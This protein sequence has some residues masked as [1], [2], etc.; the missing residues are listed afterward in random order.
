VCKDDRVDGNPG[1]QGNCEAEPTVPFVVDTALCDAY[2]GTCKDDG[3]PWRCASEAA[4][5]ATLDCTV[6]FTRTLG[7]ATLPPAAAL[8]PASTAPVPTLTA[9]APGCAYSLLGGTTQEGYDVG[10]RAMGSGDPP[11]AIHLGCDAELVVGAASNDFAPQPD[12]WILAE[13]DTADLQP[14]W[15]IVVHVTPDLVT[16][17]PATPMSCTM[18]VP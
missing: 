4:A 10:L 8:C 9:T 17:C 2:D 3:E 11:A 5:Q 7:T 15:V 13:D 18:R 1:L 12:E 16:A 14:P 6:A